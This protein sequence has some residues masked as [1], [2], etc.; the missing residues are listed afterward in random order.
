MTRSI[1]ITGAPG[2]GKS[3]TMEHL[4]ELLELQWLPDERVYRETWV[5]PLATGDGALG[6]YSLGKRRAEYSGTDALSMSASPRVLEWLRETELPDW[7]L[8]EGARLSNAR[9][10]LGLNEI[11]PLLLVHLTCPDDETDRRVEARGGG[12]PPTF[13]ASRKTASA[14]VAEALDALDI[15]VLQLDTGEWGTRE[16]AEKIAEVAFS[17]ESRYASGRGDQPTTS[18]HTERN[19]TMS[20]LTPVLF[21]VSTGRDGTR[22]VHKATC[23]KQPANSVPATPIEMFQDTAS[24][25]VGAS[26]CK[27]KFEEHF[28]EIREAQKMEAKA[29]KK[30]T[31]KAT[32]KVSSAPAPEEAD[33]NHVTVTVAWTPNV[34]KLFFRALAK[35]GTRTICDAVG[36]EHK[37]NET[38]QRVELTGD[39]ATVAMLAERLPFWWDSCN[40]ELRAWRKTSPDY[41]AFDLRT[42]DGAKAAFLA[43]QDLLR[44]MCADVAPLVAK[45]EWA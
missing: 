2:T 37:S 4:V 10:L 20:T 12:L 27:P 34:A 29:A 22:R 33:S 31:P 8:G 21:A 23:K 7:V 6:G 9:F 24:C 1:Y 39:P 32:K 45:G 16:V 36:V 38:H 18:P 19:R 14:G 44:Q 42:K 25:L 28:R 11:A 43:E 26:C 30:T 5:N 41:K 15:V 13:R 17:L 40:E 35:D 3:T